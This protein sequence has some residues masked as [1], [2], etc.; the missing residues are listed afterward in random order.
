MEPA[1]RI[2]E[3]E[4]RAAPPQSDGRAGLKVEARFAVG[5]YEIVILSPR[6]PAARNL[7]GTRASTPSPYGAKEALA[8][9]V[10][11]QMNSS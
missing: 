9:T 8:R 2:G 4:G 10:Q 6:T 5:E 11:P 1:R 3:E 7:A